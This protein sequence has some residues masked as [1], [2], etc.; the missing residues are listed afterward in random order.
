[1][2]ATVTGTELVRLIRE[3]VTDRI[4]RHSKRYL[5][6]ILINNGMTSVSIALSLLT[7]ANK[8]YKYALAFH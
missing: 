7:N 8:A 3:S 2:F 5:G 4:K 6:I 1:M